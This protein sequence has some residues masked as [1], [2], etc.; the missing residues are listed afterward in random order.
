[1][2]D[3]NEAR[4]STAQKMGWS[5]SEL[6]WIDQDYLAHECVDVD[7][8]RPAGVVDG[9]KNLPDVFHGHNVSYRNNGSGRFYYQ[10]QSGNTGC[11]TSWFSAWQDEYNHFNLNQYCGGDVSAQNQLVKF[12]KK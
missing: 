8:Q 9:E 6:A 10:F 1:M 4:A 2:A 12:V 5:E 3:V 7:Q 11:D